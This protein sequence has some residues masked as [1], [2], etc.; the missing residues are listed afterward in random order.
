RET[1][2]GESKSI[3]SFDLAA[4]RDILNKKGTLTFS[5]RDI[6]NSRRRRYIQ[7][8][9]DFFREGDFQWRARQFTLTLNYRLNQKKKRERGGRGGYDGGDGEF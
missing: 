3:Y 1:T 9:D 5:V 4:S 7:F 6:F 8:G 2:Q